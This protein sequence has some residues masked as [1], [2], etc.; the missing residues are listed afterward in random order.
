MATGVS[1]DTLLHKQLGNLLRGHSPPGLQMQGK[2]LEEDV[3]VKKVWEEQ[4]TIYYV[5]TVE[6]ISSLPLFHFSFYL[7]FLKFF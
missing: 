4:V 5:E 3:G 2:H 6:F 1:H 7:A